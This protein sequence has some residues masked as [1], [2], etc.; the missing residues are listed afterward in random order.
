MAEN[1]YII[2]VLYNKRV[3]EINS[4]ET[5]LS[6]VKRING[7][8]IISDN[9]DMIDNSLQEFDDHIIYLNNAGNIGLSKAYNRAIASI[10]NEDAWVM[11][12]DDDTELSAEYLENAY[13]KMQ[14]N[15]YSIISGIITSQNG[16]FSPV[17][18]LSLKYSDDSFI[19][20]VGEYHNIYCVNSGLCIRKKLIEKIGEFNESLFLDMIDYWLMDTLIKNDLNHISIVPGSIKQ[21]FSGATRDK[22]AA[23]KRYRITKKD[24]IEYC[25]LTNKSI[26]F[27]YGI[28][29][30]RRL[31]IFMMK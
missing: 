25:H 19:K 28:L 7:K 12:I 9:S 6:F 14:E 24:F 4:Y 11:I 2:C 26:F 3:N 10:P 31:H 27:Q 18:G 29:I 20:E 17:K 1:V 16:Y 21:S 23:L 30:K 5:V 22:S 15:N 13:S 8:L